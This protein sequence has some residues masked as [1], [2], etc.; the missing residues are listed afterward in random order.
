MFASRRHLTSFYNPQLPADR[1]TPAPGFSLSSPFHPFYRVLLENRSF[2]AFQFQG[3]CPTSI[4]T[5]VIR[6]SLD[7][8]VISFY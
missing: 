2:G 8:L 6:V 3:Y 1:V 4:C 7:L 5:K